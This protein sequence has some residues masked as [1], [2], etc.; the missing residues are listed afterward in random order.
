MPKQ[1]EI[2]DTTE[3]ERLG[4]GGKPQKVYI[5]Y[6]TTT[7]GVDG[8]VTVKESDWNAEKLKEILSA[9]TDELNLA[10]TL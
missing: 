4:P 10:L 5:V 9:R 7:L 1:Y 6:L 8:S 2:T 3:R